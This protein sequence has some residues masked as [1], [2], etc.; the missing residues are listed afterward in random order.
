M[1][2]GTLGHQRRFQCENKSLSKP[3]NGRKP[4]ILE[5]SNTVV[6]NS[7]KS[8]AGNRGTGG[9]AVRLADRC[10]I[11]EVLDNDS[12][13]AQGESNLRHEYEECILSLRAR[14]KFESYIN[15]SPSSS[16]ERSIDERS[17][18]SRAHSAKPKRNKLRLLWVL[19]QRGSWHVVTCVTYCCVTE[20]AIIGRVN[21]SI[22]IVLPLCS[23][24]QPNQTKRQEPAP[25][26]N[27]K[28][29]H[30]TFHN[31]RGHYSL[32]WH[33]KNSCAVRLIPPPC[34]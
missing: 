15:A 27:A 1:N 31:S 28:N 24:T 26:T 30:H 6:R 10:N 12:S 9:T 17:L 11:G 5:N 14:I 7:S 13:L 22:P 21:T 23:P 32:S 18:H 8:R 20:Y 29:Q 34:P 19:F 25:R 2:E 16:L 4:L 33:L 3:D